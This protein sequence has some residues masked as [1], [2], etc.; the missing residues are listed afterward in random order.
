MIR[1]SDGDIVLAGVEQGGGFG[2]PEVKEVNA[3]LFGIKCA[4]EA[5]L[6]NLVIEGDCLA[7]ELGNR[8]CRVGFVSNLN[9][10]RNPQPE[11]NPFI[12]RVENLNLYPFNF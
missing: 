5:G 11:P 7:L 1:S 8:S 6:D 4:R 12:K 10:L 2:G 3:Y 9:G